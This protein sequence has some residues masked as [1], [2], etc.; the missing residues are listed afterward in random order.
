MRHWQPWALWSLAI[1]LFQ[2]FVLSQVHIYGYL[3]PYL[4][5]LIILLAPATWSRMALLWTGAILGAWMDFQMHSGGMHMMASSLLGY[6]RPALLASVLPRA[7]E[8]DLGF[9]LSDMGAGKWITYTGLSVAAHH[10]YLFAVDAHGLYAFW[11]YV[12][13]TILSTATTTLL[14]Y[15]AA[16]FIKPSGKR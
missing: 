15:L 5:V 14:L 1:L 12:W 16:S 8:E 13:R 11:G 6:F 4:Y 2:S 10:A 7:A 9:T 3:N